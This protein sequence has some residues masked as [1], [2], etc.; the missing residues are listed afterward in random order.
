MVNGVEFQMFQ[1]IIV[2][3]LKIA[4]GLPKKCKVEP[5]LRLFYH[6]DPKIIIV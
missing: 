2:K 4:L 5:L 1:A 3:Q 6:Y